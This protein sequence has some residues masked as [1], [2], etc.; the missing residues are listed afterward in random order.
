MRKKEKKKVGAPEMTTF[1]MPSLEQQFIF[2]F[3]QFFFDK[4]SCLMQSEELLI[5]LKLYKTPALA[6]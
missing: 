3:L 4:I 2:Y 5:A 6:K 1:N